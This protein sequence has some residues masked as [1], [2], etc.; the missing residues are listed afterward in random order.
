MGCTPFAWDID[1]FLL[2]ERAPELLV[3]VGLEGIFMPSISSNSSIEGKFVAKY[4][5]LGAD[6]CGEEEVE[7]EGDG[8][9]K[10]EVGTKT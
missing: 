8:G 4:C 7:D 2:L 1:G 6:I 3:P 9:P 10:L 5:K